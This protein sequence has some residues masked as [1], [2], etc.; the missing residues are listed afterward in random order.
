M[1]EVVRILG[2]MTVNFHIKDF[3]IRRVSHMMG[4]IIEGTPA[5]KGMLPVEKIVDILDKYQKCQSAILELWTP[6]EQEIE[7]T[8]QKEEKWTLESVQYLKPFFD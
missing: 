7:K 5:G 8:I 3:S 6:P 2:P 1:E 4:F